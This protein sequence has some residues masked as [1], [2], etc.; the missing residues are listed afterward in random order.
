MG[1]TNN[2]PMQIPKEI[3][4][5]KNYTGSRLIEINN[6]TV[7][8]LNTERV[9]IVKE[10][11]PIL[12]E[13]E[14]LEGP[15]DVFYKKLAPLEEERVK[16]KA[17]MKPLSDEYTVHV[18]ALDEIQN[19]VDAVSLKLVPFIQELVKPQLSEFESAKELSVKDGKYYVEIVD[20]IE[21]EVKKLRARK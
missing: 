12:A 5:E 3:L 9:I 2:K 21:E 16:I 6:E 11:E 14:K 1:H 18:A 20:E 13:M 4:A 19:R 17:E 15:L 7:E 8:K 10:K